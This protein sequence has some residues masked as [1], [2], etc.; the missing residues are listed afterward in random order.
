MS[1][2]PHTPRQRDQYGQ[3]EPL[4]FYGQRCGIRSLQPEQSRWLSHPEF[5]A[6]LRNGR[7]QRQHRCS[8]SNA[9]ALILGL[10]HLRAMRVRIQEVYGDAADADRRLAASY[11]AAA[12]RSGEITCMGRDAGAVI[13]GHA[14]QVAEDVA[15]QWETHRRLSAEY[16]AEVNRLCRLRGQPDYISSG[17]ST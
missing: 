17:G 13:L 3:L 11:R 15:E 1:Q 5:L 6:G 12:R 8:V 7:A 4:P 9:T 10:P 16:A 2:Q 14:D